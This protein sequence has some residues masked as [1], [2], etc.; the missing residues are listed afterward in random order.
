MQASVGSQIVIVGDGVAAFATALALARKG[1]RQVRVVGAGRNGSQRIGESIPPDTRTLLQDLGIWDAF[2]RQAHQKCLGSR[3]VWGGEEV[4]YND[5]V[6]NPYGCGWHLNRNLF[7]DLLAEEAIQAGAGWQ[8]GMRL[9][10][11]EHEDG[12]GFR[13]RFRDANA[14]EQIIRA[15]FVVDATGAGS[16]F[17]RHAGS[18]HLFLDHLLCIYGFFEM[19]LDLAHYPSSTMLEAVREGWWYLAALPQRRIAVAMATDPEIARSRALHLRD[20]WFACLRETQLIGTQLNGCR[21]LAE[22]LIVRPV[23]TFC[24]DRAAGPAWFAVGDAASAYDPISSQGIHKALSDALRA[25]DALADSIALRREAWKEFD[26]FVRRDFETYTA[27]RNFLYRLE[28]R[29]LN[30]PFW[31]TRRQRQHPIADTTN[32]SIRSS[33]QSR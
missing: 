30:S 2:L 6:C 27:N 8:S 14:Q 29:W 21:F 12:C 13:L 26:D 4:G 23:L 28:R 19:P 17:A 11:C 16:V 10:G 9:I 20:N 7:E 24:L 31:M 22:P 15:R 33:S 25:A 5:F 32:S 18:R 1:V 3:S